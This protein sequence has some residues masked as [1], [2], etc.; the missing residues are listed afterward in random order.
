MRLRDFLSEA[1]YRASDVGER[2]ILVDV[3]AVPERLSRVPDS[4]DSLA[5]S[6]LNF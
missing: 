4:F 2:A 5:N 6:S 1:V 3:V